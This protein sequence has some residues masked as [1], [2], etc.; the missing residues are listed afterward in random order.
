[1]LRG[2]LTALVLLILGYSILIGAV[3]LVT[4]H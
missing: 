1:M 4:A 2:D 3:L